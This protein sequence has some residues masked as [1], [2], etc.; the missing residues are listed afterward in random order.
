MKDLNVTTKQLN[1]QLATKIDEK[2]KKTA[3]L[4]KIQDY[5]KFFETFTM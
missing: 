4:L 1:D 2:R 5:M 3:N